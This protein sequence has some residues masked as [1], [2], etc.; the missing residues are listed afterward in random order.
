M[1]RTFIAV[2]FDPAFR[3]QI[4]EIQTRFAD[5]NLKLVDPEQIHITLKFLGDVEEAS[6]PELSAALDSLTCEPFEA[7]V[8]G[9][10]AFP[11]PGN[12]RV[13]WLG[14]VGNFK[15]LHTQVEKVLEPLGF[16]K[17]RR[18]F[19]PHATLARVK[20]LK[21]AQKKVFLNTFHELKDVK[22]GSMK[23]DRIELKKS[24]LTPEG[25]IYETLHTAYL[26]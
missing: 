20:V 1:I 21:M 25:P 7:R 9:L 16:E 23:V 13:L 26:G 15:I 18:E 5:L 12:P 10:G 6:V 17:D 3:E 24:T 8:E 19:A 4:A 22:I 14:S 2:E 11:N